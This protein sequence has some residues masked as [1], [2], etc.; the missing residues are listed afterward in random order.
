MCYPLLWKIDSK[1]GE[2]DIDKKCRSGYNTGAHLRE[3]WNGRQ[4][5]LRCVWLRR[6]GS[7]PISRTNT[8][9]PDRAAGI[10]YLNRMKTRYPR[11]WITGLK[12]VSGDIAY[13]CEAQSLSAF[14]QTGQDG[15]HG[16]R[17]GFADLGG[18]RER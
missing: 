1:T 7:S 9:H 6:V 8:G 16:S 14:V 13:R 5:R 11:T 12:L 15:V 18:I 10:L 17:V 4:A 2:K 3:C